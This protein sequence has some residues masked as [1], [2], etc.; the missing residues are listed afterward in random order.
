MLDLKNVIK[1]YLKNPT[2]Y[3]I[4]ITG[5]WGSGKTHYYKNQLEELI[6][7]MPV[8]ND[9]NKKYK[10]VYVSLFGL[11]STDEIETKIV[12]DFFQSKLF[13]N[14]F[15]NDDKRKKLKITESV[16]K[17]A[18][19]GLTNLG[20]VDEY[21]PEVV[22][23]GRNALN[24]NELVICFDDLERK[25]SQLDIGDFTGYINTLNDEGIKVLLISNEDLLL[26]AGNQYKDY[27]E[28]VIGIQRQFVSDTEKSLQSIIKHKYNSSKFFQNFLLENIQI[29]LEVSEATKNNFRHIIYAIDILCPCY[30]KIKNEILDVENEISE[31]LISEIRNIT[32]LILALAI[33]FKSSELNHKNLT[34]YNL[35]FAFIKLHNAMESKRLNKKVEDSLL[36][37]F[38]EKYK[39]SDK[40]YHFY[41]TIFN[42]VTTY[43]EFDTDEF[44]AEFKSKFNLNKG[45]V[46]PQYKLLN[47]LSYSNFF[48]L[49][50]NEYK[51][52]TKELIEYAKEGRYKPNDYLTVIYF[53][54]RFND[55]FLE[56]NLEDKKQLLTAGFRQ[57]LRNYEN[58]LPDGSLIQFEMSA[59]SS[60]L[61][62]IS[63]EL[64][65][66]GMKIVNEFKD[67]KESKK[68]AEIVTLFVNDLSSFAIKYE[69]DRDLRFDLSSYPFMNLV[70]ADNL[71]ELVKK[72]DNSKLIFLNTF[73]KERYSNHQI[74]SKELET[75]KEFK[76]LLLD[77]ANSIRNEE[78]NKLRGYFLEEIINTLNAKQG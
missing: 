20:S 8:H 49:T 78:G 57:S 62:Q 15:K 33:E 22:K 63:N 72:S 21:T 16:F 52:K 13:K 60:Q 74:L 26:E 76:E 10:P 64:F 6:A 50:D 4:L 23:I 75:I 1:D 61:S 55:L 77:Y 24:S 69:L 28:K 67:K 46:L 66:E 47:E 44:V 36:E 17:I 68:K 27:K 3:A 38:L 30:L 43:D 14:Y 56:Y 51:Q 70:R 48:N 58:E 39:I 7:T 65:Q 18:F 11:K 35:D 19:R 53:V 37:L 34:D 40:D 5:A 25:N 29:L 31:K 32:K 9:K 45:E 2:D 42:F 73:L 71:I 41:T 59:K 12:I 54:E